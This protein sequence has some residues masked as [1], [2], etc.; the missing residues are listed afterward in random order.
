MPVNIDLPTD[1]DVAKIRPEQ[2]RYND[3]NSAYTT[4]H[5]RYIAKERNISLRGATTKAEI[6]RRILAWVDRYQ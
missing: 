2:F 5:L 3:A 4:A 1:F 6:C